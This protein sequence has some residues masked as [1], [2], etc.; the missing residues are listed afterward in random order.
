MESFDWGRVTESLA[1]MKGSLAVDSFDI[2]SSFILAYHSIASLRA[3]C[4]KNVRGVVEE[5]TSYSAEAIFSTK[6]SSAHQL[7][8]RIAVTIEGK[9]EI[10]VCSNNAEESSICLGD[11]ER[12]YGCLVQR[13]REL[14][15]KN[16]IK[17]IKM[18]EVEMKL[19]AALNKI[20]EKALASNI[21][22]P[23]A[24]A[25]EA[26]ISTLESHDPIHIE[27][28]KVIADLYSHKQDAPLD[29]EEAQVMSIK[30]LDWKKRLSKTIDELL[31]TPKIPSGQG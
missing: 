20:L 26:L 18:V 2:D 4:H 13:S 24:A 28:G 22:R 19:D 12:K 9:L 29:S 1:C 14:D 25:R 6:S 7:S 17:L 15:E 16:R 10:T 11:Y 31:P 3:R 5:A 30:I 23:L 21:Y 8:V 27:T